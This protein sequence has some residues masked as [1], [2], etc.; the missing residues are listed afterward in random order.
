MWNSM[1]CGTPNLAWPVARPRGHGVVC[2]LR[3]FGLKVHAQRTAPVLLLPRTMTACM[4]V[5]VC[6]C[7]G[8]C[9]IRLVGTVL[10]SV[11]C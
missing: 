4:Y 9:R 5:C 1:L 11:A 10:T 2:A 7:A 6:M 8:G 3:A